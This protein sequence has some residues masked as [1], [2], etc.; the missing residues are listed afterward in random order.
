LDWNFGFNALVVGANAVLTLG[1]IDIVN[2]KYE[3]TILNK[4][5]VWP[6]K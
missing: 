3:K 4:Y 2:Y 5:Q 1:G 6:Q